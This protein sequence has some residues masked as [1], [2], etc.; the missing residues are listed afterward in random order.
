[1]SE[2]L[3]IEIVET[4]GG[5]VP[6][7]N[8]NPGPTPNSN[9]GPTPN[10]N[11]GPDLFN[12]GDLDTSARTKPKLGK[13]ASD[14]EKVAAGEMNPFLF[15]VNVVEKEM[16]V[17]AFAASVAGTA[18][19]TV[20]SLN[21]DAAV[22]G[23]SALTKQLPL[24]GGFFGTLVDSAHGLANALDGTAHRL[25]PFN[26]L[27]AESVAMSHVNQMV[28]DMDRADRLG[29]QLAEFME[30]KSRA[31]QSLQDAMA[32]MLLQF[33]P[34]INQTM[35]AIA[36]WGIFIDLFT[37]EVGEKGLSKALGNLD[38]IAKNT[39]K[40]VDEQDY[41]K[42]PKLLEQIREAMTHS[43]PDMVRPIPGRP[44]PVNNDPVGRG[45]GPEARPFG[46]F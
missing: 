42:Q 19:T 26:G 38:K 14:L 17:L 29:P 20:A 2:K 41:A 3:E 9:P 31:S 23:L 30:N 5:R 44:I 16:K 39:Q 1:V 27:L 33:M 24:V 25:A 35:L 15:A 8:S 22:N 34:Q 46:G 13:D 43:R 45:F 28:G 11:P 7:P 21:P 37:R 10:S 32:T 40:R 18:L 12:W 4:G 6:T 36:G